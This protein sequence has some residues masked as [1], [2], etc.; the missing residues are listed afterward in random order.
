MKLFKIF[1]T[2]ML[3]ALL[4]ACSS[5]GPSPSVPQEEIQ[6]A[7]DVILTQAG[8]IPAVIPGSEN[9]ATP[10]PE[11]PTLVPTTT[12]LPSQTPYPTYTPYPTFT[13]FVVPTLVH[14]TPTMFATVKPPVGISILGVQKNTAVSVQANN[15]SPNTVLKIRVGPYDTFSKDAVQVGTINSGN[16]GTI[17]FTALLPAVV[18]DVEKVTIRLDGANGEYAYTYFNNVTSG[19]VPTVSAT[20]TSSICEVSVSPTLGSTKTSGADFDAVWTV[21]NISGKTWELYTTDYKYIKGT[22]M[23]NHANAYD[24]D[25]VVK[26]GESVTL[27]VDMTAPT[28]AGT[29]STTWA[30]SQGSTI[31]CTL[32]VKIVVK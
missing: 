5:A 6:Q 30:L 19:T 28:D 16:A 27:T 8:G 32:P 17:K 18:Q 23:Q 2:L 7:L 1:I 10:L 3:T 11:L 25:Q 9:T 26:S 14:A 4:A 12:L 29:Y 22:E 31:I 24:L 20:V 13:Q 21:K 15:F